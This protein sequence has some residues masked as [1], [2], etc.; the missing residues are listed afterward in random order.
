MYG[1]V[2]SAELRVMFLLMGTQQA[3]RELLKNGEALGG[4]P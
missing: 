1:Y 2:L 4:S 3:L